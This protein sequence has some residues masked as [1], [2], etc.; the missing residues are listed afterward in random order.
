MALVRIAPK[1]GVNTQLTQVAN[2]NGMFAAN[3]IRYRLGLIEK[4]GGW[5]RV[6]DD[7]ALGYI[8][9]MHTW[10][11]L[12]NNLNLIFG[13]D[14]G[15]QLIVNGLVNGTIYN[16]Q[17]ITQTASA[18]DELTFCNFSVTIATTNVTVGVPTDFSIGVGDTIVLLMPVS[19]GGRLLA[20]NSTFTV[21]SVGTGSF[22]FTMPS[23][24]VYTETATTGIPRFVF[25]LETTTCTVTFRAHGK[26]PGGTFLVDQTT[27]F[28]AEAFVG[29]GVGFINIT[30][31]AGSTI[32]ILTTPTADTFTFNWTPYGNDT[33]STGT[34]DIYEGTI[35]DS[36]G[37]ES[38]GPVLAVAQGTP[39]LA[40]SHSWFADNFG[41]IGLMV[42]SGSPLLAYQPSG[43]QPPSGSHPLLTTVG[44]ASSPPTAPQ[45]NNAMFVAMPQAQVFLLGTEP[46]MGSGTIDPLLL[47]FSDAGD[48]TSY[49]PTVSNQAGS[50]RLSRGSQIIGGIQAPQATLV[51]TDSDCWQVSYIGP[52]LVYGFTIM[53]TNCGLVASKAIV[54]VGRNTYWL[55]NQNIWRFGDGGI[56]VLPCSVWDYMFRDLDVENISKCH[57]GSSVMTN[58][59]YFF[60]PSLE[61]K[62]DAPTNLLQFTEQFDQTAAWAASGLSTITD[63]FTD[64]EGDTDAQRLVDNSLTSRHGVTQTIMKTAEA[65]QYTLAVYAHK[66]STRNLALFVQGGSG[67]VIV[68]FNPVTGATGFNG[69]YTG[70]DFTV[71]AVG[72]TT[73]SLATGI[74]GNG[75]LRYYITFTTDAS[76][77]LAINLLNA[78]ATTAGAET[79]LGNG[80]SGAIIWGAQLSLGSTLMDYEAVALASSNECTRYIKY[81]VVENLW[82]TGKWPNGAM[83][84]AWWD[85]QFS[86]QPLG[87]DQNFR[88]QIHEE[89]Y[90]DDGAPMEDVYFETGYGAVEDGNTIFAVDQIQPDCKWFGADGGAIYI[91]LKTANYP[92]AQTNSFGPYSVTPTTRNIST[93]ARA[94]LIAVR[95]EW[96]AIAGFSAR[97]GAMAYRVKPAGKR[98]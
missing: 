54:T 46:V 23:S 48:Y 81:N 21:T 78:N 92:G 28:I 63:G 67:S 56:S 70:I 90:D 33:F 68:Y 74:A 53:G 45:Q 93:R 5:R 18:D 19:I 58:E 65:T 50:F 24:A 40:A 13:T 26:S 80:S 31:P 55:G 98:P 52:P 60:F 72:A 7:A 2:S 91:T 14:G 69:L 77:T 17:I 38:F 57:A 6:S 83:R 12:G 10:Q 85:S 64:P 44:S 4:M 37:V 8:R 76:S 49:T 29:R 96:A 9:V 87:G 94:K 25:N 62:P 71:D 41:E 75:W 1:P 11:D 59:I 36:N 30:I 97:V 3:L 86:N 15:P 79:Y 22:T 51:L 66:N 82:D 16:M 27:Q 43:T 35:V 73:D 61:D 89:G 34:A 39:T 95:Y 42:F 84:T 88:I 47:R 20:T 32:S